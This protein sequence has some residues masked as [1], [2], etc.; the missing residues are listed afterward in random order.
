MTVNQW[1]LDT[2]N[3]R[4]RHRWHCRERPS[5]ALWGHS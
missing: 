4:I 5:P 3:K 1:R 2:G